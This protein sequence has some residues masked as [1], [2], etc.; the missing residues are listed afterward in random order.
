[1]NWNARRR[2]GEL[3]SKERLGAIDMVNGGADALR[4]DVEGDGSGGCLQH[5]RPYLERNAQSRQRIDERSHPHGAAVWPVDRW[6]VS[7][8]ACARKAPNVSL[9]MRIFVVSTPAVS[10]SGAKL[11]SISKGRLRGALLDLWAH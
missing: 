9:C 3:H 1:M 5:S 8:I 10:A 6:H 4:R 7:Q 11:P 2:A